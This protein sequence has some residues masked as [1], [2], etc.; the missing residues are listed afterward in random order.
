M[1]YAPHIAAVFTAALF[2]E[3]CAGPVFLGKYPYAE[4]WRKAIVTEVGAHDRLER[5]WKDCAPAS[6]DQPSAERFARVRFQYGRN[7]YG[8]IVAV[9]QGVTLAPGDAVYVNSN[10]CRAGLVVAGPG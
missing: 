6:A 3:A 9:P 10:D 4:G 7:W 2:L 8:M 5:A 1:I